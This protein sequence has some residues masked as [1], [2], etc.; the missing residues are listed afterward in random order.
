MSK[1]IFSAKQDIYKNQIKLMCQ[2]ISM[3]L[4]RPDARG[5]FKQGESIYLSYIWEKTPIQL[6]CAIC[7]SNMQKII[8]LN[9][10]KYKML[11]I[12]NVT[13]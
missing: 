3:E 6:T 9:V 8:L 11:Q 12:L 7:L 2:P 1:N 4:M 10:T 13:E 5:P